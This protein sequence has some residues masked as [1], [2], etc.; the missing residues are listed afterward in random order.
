M[1]G[2]TLYRDWHWKRSFIDINVVYIALIMI[3]KLLMLKTIECDNMKLMN[4]ELRVKVNH[5]TSQI[6]NA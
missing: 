5:M 4:N 3:I 6:R 1:R 2:V